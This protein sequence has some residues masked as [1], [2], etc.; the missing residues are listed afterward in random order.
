M[1]RSSG[2]CDTKEPFRALM[3]SSA[4]CFPSFCLHQIFFWDAWLLFPGTSEDGFPTAN[5][6][7]WPVDLALLF[8]F[9]HLSVRHV[10]NCT[11]QGCQK[12][13]PTDSSVPVLRDHLLHVNIVI[14]LSYLNLYSTMSFTFF[15][16]YYTV[17]LKYI[18]RADSGHCPWKHK[19]NLKIQFKL[20]AH[21]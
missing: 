11:K 5:M 18:F 19:D 10:W 1:C 21:H 8:G 12:Y 2:R 17:Y 20:A 16:I 3:L 4:L 14:L 13:Y 6:H 7:F 9:C 15:T